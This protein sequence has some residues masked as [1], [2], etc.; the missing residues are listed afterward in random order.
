MKNEEHTGFVS[1]I[2][3]QFKGERFGPELQLLFKVSRLECGNPED[4]YVN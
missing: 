1:G 2:E 3:D 4:S